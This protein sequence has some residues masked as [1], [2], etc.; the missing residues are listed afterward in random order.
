MIVIFLIGIIG[1]VIG[2]SMKGSLDEGRAFKTK[3]GAERVR[4]L[5]LLEVAKGEVT[6]EDAFKNPDRCL[7]MTG[8]V[9]DVKKAME[10]GW[11][12]RFKLDR[13]E[14]DDGDIVVISEKL[15]AYEAK[16]KQ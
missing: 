9:T 6:M 12:V 8:V 14:K 11:G 2:Y 7:K 5:L 13:N 16:K 10:D 15:Q 3:M 1:S 4:E